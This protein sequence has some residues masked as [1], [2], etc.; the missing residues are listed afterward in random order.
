MVS[1]GYDHAGMYARA[2]ARR[3]K[4]PLRNLLYKSQPTAPQ[5]RLDFDERR[6]NIRGS[7]ALRRG[8][9]VDSERIILVD[10]VYTTGST[11][12]ECAMILKKGLGVKVYVWTFARTVRR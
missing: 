5:N 12:A 6:K 4:L 1:R 7:F 11:A 2:L 8:A 10:D 9:W 3:L